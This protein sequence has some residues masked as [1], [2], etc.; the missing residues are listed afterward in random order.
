MDIVMI[1]IIF[2]LVLILASLGGI[3]KLLKKKLDNDERIINRLDLLW[4][5]ISQRQ[6]DKD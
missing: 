4:K 3:H 5:E 1:L 6:I 2:L